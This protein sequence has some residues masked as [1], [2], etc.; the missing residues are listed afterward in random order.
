MVIEQK[1]QEAGPNIKSQNSGAQ[2]GWQ[3]RRKMPVSGSTYLK[4]HAEPFLCLSGQNVRYAESQG[5][6]WLPAGKPMKD[7]RKSKEVIAD[8]RRAD[9]N[10]S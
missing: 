7:T 8:D 1:R 2:P 9:M 6:N 4:E 3:K 5:G 10:I